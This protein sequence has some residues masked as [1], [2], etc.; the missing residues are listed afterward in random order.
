MRKKYCLLLAVAAC[1]LSVWIT[2]TYY[3]NRARIT[4]DTFTG[5]F[6]YVESDFEENGNMDSVEYLAVIRDDGNYQY[7]MYKASGDEKQ[8]GECEYGGDYLMF[9]TDEHSYVLFCAGEKYYLVED[10]TNTKQLTKISE[11]GIVD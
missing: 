3:R 11:S 9:S 5:T 4:E 7:C 6:Q 1:L 8:E 10:G 2:G